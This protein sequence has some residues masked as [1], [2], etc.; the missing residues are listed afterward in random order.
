[1]DLLLAEMLLMKLL[2]AKLLLAMM[3]LAE[4]LLIDC[5]WL[6]CCYCVAASKFVSIP[7]ESSD[8]RRIHVQL[9]KHCSSRS[10]Q[11]SFPC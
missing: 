10:D 3:L 11:R 4:L 8:W 7:T 5:C 2:L 1:V 9:Q 6:D